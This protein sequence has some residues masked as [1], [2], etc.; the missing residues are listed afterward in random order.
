MPKL[1]TNIPLAEYISHQ[2]QDRL[3]NV[4][5]EAIHIFPDVNVMQILTEIAVSAVH[6]AY[7]SMQIVTASDQE[8][9]E[10]MLLVIGKIMEARRG[11][12]DDARRKA[13]RGQ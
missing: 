9:E 2:I 7:Q 13:R 3:G 11:L 8:S 5:H 10:L 6:C 12:S 1:H 4:G